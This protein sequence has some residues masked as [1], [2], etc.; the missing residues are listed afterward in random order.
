VFDAELQRFFDGPRIIPKHACEWSDSILCEGRA[1]LPKSTSKPVLFFRTNDFE[2]SKLMLFSELSF[3]GS[4][5][6]S[7]VQT[8]SGSFSKMIESTFHLICFKGGGQGGFLLGG[9]DPKIWHSGVSEVKSSRYTSLE[10]SSNQCR[11][12][13]VNE[14]QSDLWLDKFYEKFALIYSLFF[15]DFY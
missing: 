10:P 11:T 4:T 3:A 6:Q 2:I 12:T 8:R 1:P 7:E 5:V 13:H 9:R 14:S 15:W